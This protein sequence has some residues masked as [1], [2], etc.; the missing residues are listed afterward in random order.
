MTRLTSKF[1]LLM[2]AS[3]AIASPLNLAV[4]IIA[5]TAAPQDDTATTTDVPTTTS[6]PTTTTIS[7]AAIATKT[8][9]GCN[10][11]GTADTALAARYF[12][13]ASYAD[14]L[15]CQSTCRGVTACISYSWTPLTSNCTLYNSWM[16]DFNTGDTTGYVV[17]SDD[18]GTFFS[19]KYPSDGSD[20]CYKAI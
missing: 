17:L 20:F 10:V 16:D 7:S 9:D 2:I 18:S 8:I 12:G 5:R 13:S 15:K 4:E 6:T 11:Q 1:F 14:V 3:L 19:D